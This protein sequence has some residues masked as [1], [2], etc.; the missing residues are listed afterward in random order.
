[1]KKQ[2]LLIAAIAV[3][4]IGFASACGGGSQLPRPDVSFAFNMNDLDDRSIPSARRYHMDVRID[5]EVTPEQI[6]DIARFV[7]QQIKNDRD[8]QALTMWFFD[9]R[10]Q[11]QHGM[12]ASLGGATYAPG[13]VLA[14]AADVRLGD[15]DAFEFDFNIWNKD[16]SIRPTAKELDIFGRFYAMVYVSGNDEQL[17]REIIAERSEITEDE[18]DDIIYRSREWIMQRIRR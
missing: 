12:S 16:W 4:V 13:G 11:I 17:T 15:Y 3:L 18:L 10:S 2:I 6:E 7:A 14:N 1:M 8:F 5:E 9:H